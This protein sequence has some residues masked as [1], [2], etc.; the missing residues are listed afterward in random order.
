MADADG[1]FDLTRLSQR[2]LLDD[3][4]RCVLVNARKSRPDLVDEGGNLMAVEGS[5]YGK[6]VDT[7]KGRKLGRFVGHHPTL[8][9]DLIGSQPECR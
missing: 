5:H 8:L 3:G 1:T 4:E 9:M 7:S 6:A 2:A